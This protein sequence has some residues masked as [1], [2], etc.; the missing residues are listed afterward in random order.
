LFDGRLENVSP[1][2]LKDPSWAVPQITQLCNFQV[3]N[4][5]QLYHAAIQAGLPLK[6]VPKESC[7]QLFAHMVAAAIKAGKSGEPL[8]LF[9]DLRKAEVDLSASLFSSAVKL[10]T[11]K[12]CYAEALELYDFMTEDPLFILADKSIWSCLLFCAIEAKHCHRCNAFFKNLKACGTPSGKDF[13]NIVRLAALNSD[14]ESSLALIQEMR[15]HNIELDCVQYNTTLATLTR[16]GKV[17]EA[18][19]LLK[20]MEGVSGAAD[21]ITYNTIMKGY[22]RS[23][24]L[25]ECFE[26][27]E[28]MKAKNI[29]PSQVTY[30]IL[31]D[32]CI[33][34][35]Q[36]A[37]AMQVFNDMTE[38]KCPMNTVLYTTL[39]KGFARAN[40][41]EEAMKMYRE[42]SKKHGVTPDLITFSILIKANCD[43]DRL[44]QALKLLEEMIA[45][46][47]KPDEVVFNN[48]IA[49]CG[50]LGN[51]KLGKQLYE[52]MIKSGVKPSNATFSILIRVFHRCKDL[53]DAVKLLKTEP[54]KHNVDPEPRLFLQLIQSS[55]RERQ[56]KHAVEVYEMLSKRSAPNMA[57]HNSI[58][59]TCMRLNMYD[60][61][62]EIISIAAASGSS[63]DARDVNALLEAVFKKGKMQVVRS[64]VTSMDKMGH[65]IDPKYLESVGEV[66]CA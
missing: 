16:T 53:D 12:A 44:E 64:C 14:W 11:S 34:E 38:S 40:E 57:T 37:R 43:N 18:C 4:A 51:A 30:G 9:K 50:A 47:L 29:A 19:E 66:R 62:A 7:L 54:A 41:L 3:H 42:M 48:L 32:G 60:T 61:A 36:M 24:Q 58:L 23:G 2:L 46:G 59:V 26:L 63:V 65:Q 5:L 1:K 33:N 25:E 13:G 17:N 21:A 35:N 49:G 20:T 15:D 55:I 22:A 27:F 56:G 10:S 8:K 45:L 28:R 39:I 6:D 52:D 31:L